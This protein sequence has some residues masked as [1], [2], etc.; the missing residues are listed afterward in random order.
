MTARIRPSNIPI[1]PD[2]IRLIAVRPRKNPNRLPASAPR[3]APNIAIAGAKLR[4]VP[5]TPEFV[6]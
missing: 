1:K 4:A 2:L 3:I 6:L 5:K